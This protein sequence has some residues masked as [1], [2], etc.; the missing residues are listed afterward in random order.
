M[1]KDTNRKIKRDCKCIG[2]C[3]MATPFL[4][5]RLKQELPKGIECQL[6]N[7]RETRSK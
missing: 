5:E 2:G 4:N 7:N 3:L 1:D 6:T